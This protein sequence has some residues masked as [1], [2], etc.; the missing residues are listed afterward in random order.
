DQEKHRVQ[1]L[2][3]GSRPVGFIS[4]QQPTASF[5]CLPS[6]FWQTVLD[7]PTGGGY[8]IGQVLHPMKPVGYRAGLG[9]ALGR[10]LTEVSHKSS[11]TC[12]TAA[13]WEALSVAK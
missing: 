8:P 2:L 7:L 3:V 1:F 5:E 9:Q 4:D 10:D 6:G 13:R 12:S 11:A